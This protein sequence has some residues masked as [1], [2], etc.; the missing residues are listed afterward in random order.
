MRMYQVVHSSIGNK[1]LFFE[2]RESLETHD[3]IRVGNDVMKILV[4]LVEKR[5]GTSL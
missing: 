2:L 1:P 5:S 4:T 3:E